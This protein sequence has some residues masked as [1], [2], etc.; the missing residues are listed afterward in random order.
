MKMQLRVLIPVTVIAL[1]AACSDKS[2]DPV[3]AKPLATTDAEP[4]PQPALPKARETKLIR[5]RAFQCES[6]GR[7]ELKD[8]DDNTTRVEINSQ[9]HVLRAVG[10]DSGS[11]L[12]GD[13]ISVRLFDDQATASE[14]GIVLYAGCRKAA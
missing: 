4:S 2:A 10:V 9:A 8:Y 6:G 5:T 13:N 1:L 11:M 3:A 7:L 14:N 12:Q